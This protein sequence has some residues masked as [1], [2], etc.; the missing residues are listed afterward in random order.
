[1]TTSASAIPDKPVVV[2]VDDDTAV[3]DSLKFALD[4]EGFEVRAFGGGEA[5]LECGVPAAARCLVLDFHLAEMDGLELLGLL[6]ARQIS[7][8]A[9]LITSNPTQRLR[10][11]AGA[12]GIPIVEKP[13]LSD[14]LLETIRQV[15]RPH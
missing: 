4:L 7:L 13:L 3:E 10:R 8:P 12:L 6:R 2:L 9:I 1:M 15:T 11:R 5:L 14:A